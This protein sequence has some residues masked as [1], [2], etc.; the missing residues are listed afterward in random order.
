M[1]NVTNAYP[2]L[3]GVLLDYRIPDGT[4]NGRVPVPAGFT[5]SLAAAEAALAALSNA[6]LEL[7]KSGG[8]AV[9]EVD[10]N[11]AAYTALLA[12]PEMKAA[13]EFITAYCAEFL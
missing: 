9:G 12:R 6:D 7:F 3:F 1:M 8:G 4:P 2:T 5:G 13:A 11:E 10:D